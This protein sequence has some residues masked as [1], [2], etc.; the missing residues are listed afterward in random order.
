MYDFYN[1][2]F[3]KHSLKLNLGC[4]LSTCCS[5]A[6]LFAVHRKLCLQMLQCLLAAWA[7]ALRLLPAPFNFFSFSAFLALAVADWIQT[8][9]SEVNIIVIPYKRTLCRLGT[10][11][12]P[13]C[14]STHVHTFWA[15]PPPIVNSNTLKSYYISYI[16]LI[17]RE[18]S[19]FTLNIVIMNPWP[20]ELR[21]IAPKR[22]LAGNRSF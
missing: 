8:T 22:D 2:S 6:P 3:G 16:G 17:L 14:L 20:M 1:Y 5:R 9:N 15:F 18:I 12:A 13:T 4:L 10:R 11:H 19:P 7:L 21:S